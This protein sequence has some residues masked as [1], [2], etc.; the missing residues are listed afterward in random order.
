MPERTPTAVPDAVDVV[1]VTCGA[2]H[3]CIVNPGGSASCW[4]DGD[5]GQLGNEDF[6]KRQQ[7]TP[8]IG[9]A[10]V[11]QLAAGLHHSCALLS[12]RT[13]RCWGRGNEGELGDGTVH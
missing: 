13:A 5:F 3:A 8:V 1:S 6:L 4:G 12:D 9:I 7:A 11:T 2:N 10:D